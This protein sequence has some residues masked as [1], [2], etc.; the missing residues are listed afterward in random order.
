MRSVRSRYALEHLGTPCARLPVLPSLRPPHSPSNQVTKRHPTYRLLLA[1]TPYRPQHIRR[2]AAA[3]VT[4][5]RR[6]VRTRKC[7]TFFLD[8]PR[9]SSW[10]DRRSSRSAPSKPAPKWRPRSKTTLRRDGVCA[11]MTRFCPSYTCNLSGIFNLVP[12]QVQL[13]VSTSRS[14]ASATPSRSAC[15]SLRYPTRQESY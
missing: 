1:P 8:Y 12:G 5:S 15:R 3:R 11:S 7:V 4:L 13:V 2:S 6:R 9:A 10:K 14:S